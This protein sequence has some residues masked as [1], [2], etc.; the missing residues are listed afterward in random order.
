MQ[1]KLGLLLILLMSSF[2][3][4]A[5]LSS[6]VIKDA[7][8]IKPNVANVIEVRFDPGSAVTN[9]PISTVAESITYLP[10]ETTKE[11]AFGE[12]SQIEATAKYYIIWD[13]VS[14][15]ILFFDKKG[16]FVR[17]IAS[18]DQA[19]PTPFKKIARFTVNEAKNELMFN[20][21]HSVYLY[22][23]NLEGKFI[24]TVK[25]P[26]FIAVSYL[27]FNKFDAWYFSYNTDFFKSINSGVSNLLI[28][29]DNLKAKVY[30]PFDTTS[31]TSYQE[32][33][34]IEANL[35]NNQ[36]G[37]R[38]LTNVYDYNVYAIDS[39]A[40]VSTAFHF[41]MPAI[42][43][44]PDDFLTN[45]KYNGKHKEYTDARNEVFYAIGDFYSR[46]NNLLFKLI[47]HGRDLTLLYNIKTQNLV[48]IPDMMPDKL[49]F[50]LPFIRK[51]TFSV[52]KDNTFI[53][54]ISAAMLF[55][56]KPKPPADKTWI[57]NLP[58]H[59]TAFF[60]AGVQQNPVL[61]LIRFKEE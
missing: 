8:L 14:N 47:G 23:Y 18:T 45:K 24:K 49:S 52:D 33:M 11:S 61:T 40:N 17:R 1:H 7:K 15:S 53:S 30:L 37:V 55:K 31:V 44:V 20:D 16:K 35:F 34:G 12:V 48:S 46:K 26:A 29:E 56:A 57:T 2:R 4:D 21:R 22:Y 51:R 38:Y 39:L 28:V 43:T 27:S 36:N 59:M 13:V 3:V 6:A 41:T 60:K 25:K 19:L 9:E 32:L 5:Q 10:L 42:N 54:V 58:T 50:N